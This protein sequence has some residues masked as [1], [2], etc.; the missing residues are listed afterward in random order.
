MNNIQFYYRVRNVSSLVCPE[1]DESRP[2]SSYIWKIHSY[3][4]LSCTPKFPSGHFPLDFLTEILY[5][6]HFSP[7]RATRS[8]YLFLF[9]WSFHGCWIQQNIWWGVQIT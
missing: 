4:A 9:V 5:A 2:L 3:T 6:S 1:P 8:T 7:I